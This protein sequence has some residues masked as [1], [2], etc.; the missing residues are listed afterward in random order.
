MQRNSRLVTSGTNSLLMLSASHPPTVSDQAGAWQQKN[1]GCRLSSQGQTTLGKPG[2]DHAATGVCEAT[3][4]IAVPG[5]SKASSP[6]FAISLI[7]CSRNPRTRNPPPQR[8]QTDVP[9]S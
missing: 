4:N 2:A 6:K 8:N 3:V 7:P 1:T 5:S 9:I